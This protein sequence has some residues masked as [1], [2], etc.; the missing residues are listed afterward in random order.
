MTVRHKLCGN[1]FSDMKGKTCKNCGYTENRVISE[2]DALSIGTKLNGRYIVGKTLGR[3]GFAITY[4]AYDEIK[5]RAVAIKEY[6]PK[7][8]VRAEDNITIEPMTSFQEEEFSEGL[9]GFFREV[10]IIRNF[11]ESTDIL[12]LY[13]VFRMN[14]TAYYAMEFYNGISLKSFVNNG[15]R[16]TEGQATD[17]AEK[18]LSA[19][20]VI[21][22]GGIL[23]RDISPDNI[24][25]CTGGRAALIDFGSA[26]MLTKGDQQ[27][28]SVILKDGFAPLEQYQ[29][30]SSQ[31]IWTDIY[32]LGMSLFYGLTGIY[33]ENPIIRLEDDS[34]FTNETEKLS[35]DMRDILRKACEVKK[36]DRFAKA[37]D[38]LD[39]IRNSSLTCEILIPGAV[40]VLEIRK[41]KN[42]KGQ[43]YIAVASAFAALASAVAMVFNS[44]APSEVKIGGEMF[45]LD[46]VELDLQN[47]EL[48]NS[49]IS[50]LRHMKKLKTLNLNNNYITDMSCLAEL[51]ELEFF[52]F[53]NNSISDISFMKNMKHLKHISGNNNNVSDISVLRNMTELE[54]VYMGDNYITDISPLE[55]S[56]GIMRVGFDEAEIDNIDVLADKTELI[57]AGFS[58]CGLESIEPLRELKKLEFVY[59]GRNNLTDVSPL[60]GCDI[61]ELYLDNNRLSGCT[62][63]FEGITLNGFAC[64]E[65][66][67]FTE[68][69]IQNIKNKM[70]GEFDIYY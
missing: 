41:R 26:R 65:G 28:M 69:E 7:S 8:A 37:E 54:M 43:K 25:L 19:L 24:M 13:D 11:S 49:Q 40:P 38:M 36:E 58:G 10:D 12:G 23:H 51:T 17:I 47:R 45:P 27:D 56:K 60:I 48:T 67:G 5:N 32:S 2:H 30:K 50:N 42:R 20:S 64:I 29:R 9:E 66:N 53:D 16:L 34:V 14:G 31:G 59:F 61:K 35:I 6:Y 3:G 33:P 52:Y 70:N 46:S 39:R 68:D 63:T 18:L 55:N 1:C 21:H 22:N 62:D 57:M 44:D 15:N 4:L